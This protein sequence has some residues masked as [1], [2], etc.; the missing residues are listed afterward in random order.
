MYAIQLSLPIENIKTRL[1]IHSSVSKGMKCVKG[2]T[3][4]HI[5]MTSLAL[6]QTRWNTKP[7]F[8]NN[9]KSRVKDY[10]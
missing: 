9:K 4:Q 2:P 6:L 1:K 3:L 7:F 10:N 5:T 8:S